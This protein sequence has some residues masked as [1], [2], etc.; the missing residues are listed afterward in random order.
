MAF[1]VIEQLLSNAVKY[2]SSGGITIRTCTENEQLC[3]IIEDTGI[4]I[5]SEDLPRLFEKDSLV[6][7]EEW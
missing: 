2:T 4:G 3:I 6:T 1:V 7:T 5:R